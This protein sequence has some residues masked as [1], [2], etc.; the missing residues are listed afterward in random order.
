MDALDALWAFLMAGAISFA[1]TPPVARLPRRLGV[2]HHPRE[3]DLHE[4]PVPGL[5]GLAILVAAIVPAAI[6]LPAGEE[7]RGIVLR[8]I[9]ITLVGAIDDIRDGGPA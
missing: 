2:I 3:R 8:A 5:G 6:F 1:A 4:R 7:T 9:A